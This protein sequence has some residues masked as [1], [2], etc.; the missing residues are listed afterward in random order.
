M[1]GSQSFASKKLPQVLGLA[2][3]RSY[4]EDTL[5]LRV[6]VFALATQLDGLAL[7]ALPKMLQTTHGSLHLGLEVERAKTLLIRG[8]ASSVGL[9][10]LA[11]ARRPVC[12]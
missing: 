4:A 3:D 8:G 6:H 2:F 7:A 12:N 9:A 5:V 11:W 10:A 1:I